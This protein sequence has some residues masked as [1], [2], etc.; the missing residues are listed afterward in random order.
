MY[1]PSPGTSSKMMNFQPS[2]KNVSPNTRATGINTSAQES[3]TTTESEPHSGT[4]VMRKE[5]FDTLPMFYR[6][7]AEVCI[8]HGRLI[9]K[10]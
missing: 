9:L 3:K 1:E 7:V 4:P 5:I 6:A 2:Q 8:E 10:N